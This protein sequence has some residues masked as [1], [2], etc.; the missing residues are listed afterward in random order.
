M[1]QARLSFSRSGARLIAASALVLTATL[2]S[3]PFALDAS[4]AQI[5][6]PPRFA[7][8]SGQIGAKAF[9]LNRAPR[10]KP[11]GVKG[12]SLASRTPSKPPKP[13]KPPRGSSGNGPSKDPRRPPVI[14][15]PYPFPPVIIPEPVPVAI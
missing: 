5:S 12:S 9:S 4:A 1:F 2:A 15:R 10:I 6:S 7:A 8:V 11:S 13:L 14:V 3:I